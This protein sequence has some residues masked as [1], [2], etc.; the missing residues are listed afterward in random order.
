MGAEFVIA[1]G[2]DTEMMA[3]LGLGGIAV[4]GDLVF[5]GGMAIDLRTLKRPVEADTIAAETR[6][7]FEGVQ[8]SLALV[9]CTLR[10]VAKITCYVEDPADREEMRATVDGLFAP[11]QAPERVTHVAGIGGDCRVEFEVLAVAPHAESGSDRLVFASAS[12]LDPATQRRVP[13]AESLRDEVRVCLERLER[14]LGDAGLTLR[15]LAKVTCWVGDEAHRMEFIYAYRDLLA[16]AP[17]PSRATFSTGL[18][19]DCRVQIDAIAARP[20]Q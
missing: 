13:E 20:A 10:D 14:R 16:P 18:P 2:R 9:G 11:G 15:D 5:T 1:P 3:K 12:A 4:V 8:R 7:C 19:G 17:Y 6:I